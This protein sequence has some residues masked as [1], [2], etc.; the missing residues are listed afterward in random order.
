MISQGQTSKSTTKLSPDRGYDREP[1]TSDEECQISR[2]H[3]PLSNAEA[4]TWCFKYRLFGE[5]NSLTLSHALSKFQM[6]SVF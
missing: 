6:G 5:I 1:V 2:R 3:H 4:H